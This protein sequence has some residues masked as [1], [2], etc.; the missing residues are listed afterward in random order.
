MKGVIL[1]ISPAKWKT[2]NFGGYVVTRQFRYI[3]FL[4]D[5]DQKIYLIR[6][7]EK[8]F[9][10]LPVDKD[11]N[12]CRPR[13]G[14]IAIIEH[15]DKR[16]FVLDD[17]VKMLLNPKVF[18]ILDHVKME[19]TQRYYLE[20]IYFYDWGVIL[21]NEQS[22]CVLNKENWD[23]LT[24]LETSSLLWKLKQKLKE[25]ELKEC[26][27]EI[28]TTFEVYYNWRLDKYWLYHRGN[29]FEWRLTSENLM[30]MKKIVIEEEEARRARL[31]MEEIKLILQ[32]KLFL[33]WEDILALARKY[34]IPEREVEEFAKGIVW[35]KN[36]DDEYTNY[37]KAKAKKVLY[38]HEGLF[39][40]LPGGLTILE[41]PEHGKATYVFL[42][43]PN[44][45]AS[46]IEGIR[47]EQY[48]LTTYLEVDDATDPVCHYG[49]KAWRE[50]L[51]RLKKKF[52]DK[53]PWF[54]GR[55]IHYDQEQWK[56]DLEAL[57]SEVIGHD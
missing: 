5:E 23:K 33:P 49:S 41:V 20:N 22:K 57:L 42:G 31:L 39:F 26:Y 13:S 1:G 46:Q 50:I 44:F 6:M 16:S 53:F 35:K 24:G 11:G 17:F 19:S 55:I 38:G 27:V 4:N 28:T 43:E 3:R 15:F 34:T 29:G 45:I 48:N 52:P 36:Y 37:L 32:N 54:I 21:R 9:L 47:Q 30:P 56:R 12:P 2:Y 7:R 40:V 18:T 8:D 51:Y 10:K 25:D 14:D